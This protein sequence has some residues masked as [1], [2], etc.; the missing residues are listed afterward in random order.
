GIRDFHV[1][2]VQTCALPI[3]ARLMPRS[4]GEY[5]YLSQLFHPA[6]G[7]LAGWGSLLLGFSAPIAISAL[8]AAA[9][10]G[11]L[12]LEVDRRLLAALLDRKSVVEGKSRDPTYEE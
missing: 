3:L 5:L 4:G 12:G 2:G 1:T 6:L 7:Y 9:F 10:L 11:A 8:G